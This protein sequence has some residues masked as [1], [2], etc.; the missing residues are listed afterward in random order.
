MSSVVYLEGQASA[1]SNYKAQLLQMIDP[2]LS[3]HADF[4]SRT[5]SMAAKLTHLNRLLVV[6]HVD[7][8]TKPPEGGVRAIPG[9][10]VAFVVLIARLHWLMWGVT[11]SSK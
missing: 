7:M 9:S 1:S 4:V 11:L 3:A 5:P 2:G 10:R 8:R 6:S